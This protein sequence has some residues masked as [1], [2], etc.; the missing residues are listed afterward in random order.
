[1]KINIE[2]AKEV[3]MVHQSVGT[4][5][6]LG[7]DQIMLKISKDQC[8]IVGTGEVVDVTPH[9]CAYKIKSIKAAV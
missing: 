4:L 7:K 1:M 9:C 6:A 8:M 3:Q 5:F 2:Y